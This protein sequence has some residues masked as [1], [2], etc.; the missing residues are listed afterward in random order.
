MN[1]ETESFLEEL[2]GNP[3]VK[4]VILFGSHARGNARD[5]SDVD[6]IVV[7]DETKRGIEERN[8]QFF[9]LVYVTEADAKKYYLDNRDN[10]VRT[11]KIARILFDSDGSAG[12]LKEFVDK[13]EK[14][15]KQK[16][17]E[18]KL[19]HLKFDTE[20]FLRAISS[21]PK[22]T[23]TEAYYLLDIKLLNLLELFF[24]V[25]GIWKPAPKQLLG[26]VKNLDNELYNQ[27][28]E[29]YTQQ[30]EEEKVAILKSISQKVF[31]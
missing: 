17:S 5:N 23:F 27:V 2:K 8:N 29:F 31:G 6:L 7:Y 20:D 28:S 10:A 24:D 11:W 14:E 13:I 16:I 9:E 21:I 30:S 1:K 19:N 25:R 3:K 22:K 18:D 26:D 15:G 12:R 4:S